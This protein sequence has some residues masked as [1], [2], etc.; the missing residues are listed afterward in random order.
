MR[1]KVKSKGFGLPKR[2]QLIIRNNTEAWL[3]TVIAQTEPNIAYVHAVHYESVD[4][5]NP[6]ERSIVAAVEVISEY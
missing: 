6:K 1:F 3:V 5:L 2:G 4:R